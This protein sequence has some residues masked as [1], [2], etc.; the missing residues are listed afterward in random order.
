MRLTDKL[1]YLTRNGVGL[2]QIL[3][4]NSILKDNMN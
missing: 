1:F 2:V 4:I 3:D